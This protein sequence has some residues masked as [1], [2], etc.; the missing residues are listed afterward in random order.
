MCGGVYVCTGGDVHAKDSDGW[1]PMH[2]AAMEGYLKVVQALCEA[3]SS[4]G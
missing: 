2:W 3:G 1:T 4:V